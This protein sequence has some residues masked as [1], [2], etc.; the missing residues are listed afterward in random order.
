VWTGDGLGK[1]EFVRVPYTEADGVG[2]VLPRRSDKWGGDGEVVEAMIMLRRGDMSVWSRLGC[3]VL[4]CTRKEVHL[5]IS[6][7]LYRVEHD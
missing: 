2:L 4:S 6:C 5:L 1:P 3:E 7:L